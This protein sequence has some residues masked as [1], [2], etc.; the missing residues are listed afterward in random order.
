[1]SSWGKTDVAG[2]KPKFLNTADK[3]RCFFVDSTEAQVASNRA[4]G[5]TGPGWWILTTAGSRTKA[6]CLV[7]M[8]VTAVAAGD[9]ADDAT[10]A[11]A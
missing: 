11:D 4:K 2:D 10:I 6:E 9:A 8:D 1:M 7:P 5:I 3:A